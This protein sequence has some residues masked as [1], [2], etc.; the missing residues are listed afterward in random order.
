MERNSSGPRIFSTALRGISS[1]LRSITSRASANW[2]ARLFSNLRF[3][4]KRVTVASE[5]ELQRA[6]SADVIAATPA[7]FVQHTIRDP[8][9]RIEKVHPGAKQRDHTARRF[10]HNHPPVLSGP[11]PAFCSELV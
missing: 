11:Q 10:A 6:S 4:Q 2:K 1:G 3:L 8:L 5:V 9:F 7:V